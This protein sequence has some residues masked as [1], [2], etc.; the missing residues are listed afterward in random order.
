VALAPQQLNRHLLLST[1]VTTNR[2]VIS[3]KTS[4]F[5]WWCFLDI[6]AA[7]RL[8]QTDATANRYLRIVSV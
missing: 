4:L 6:S 5:F 8:A 7:R 2:K 1:F 3:Q